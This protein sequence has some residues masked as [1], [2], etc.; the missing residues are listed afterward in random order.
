MRNPSIVQSVHNENVGSVVQALLLSAPLW[1]SGLAFL[2]AVFSEAGVERHQ[3]LK[4]LALA[5]VVVSV[6]ALAAFAVMES[7]RRRARNFHAL[8]YRQTKHR[9]LRSRDARP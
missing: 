4:F 7:E 2:A 8:V 5:L 9:A 1:A 6:S 3:G